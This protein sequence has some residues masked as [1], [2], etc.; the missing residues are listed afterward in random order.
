M[1]FIIILFRNAKGCHTQ[2]NKKTSNTN[3]GDNN[4]QSKEF[5]KKYAHPKKEAYH[6]QCELCRGRKSQTNDTKE[7]QESSSKAFR[8]RRESHFEF[9]QATE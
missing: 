1:F 9:F 2:T 7:V 6:K 5:D 8:S 3:K 4:N